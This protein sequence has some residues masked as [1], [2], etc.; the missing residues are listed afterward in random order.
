MKGNKGK[1][2]VQMDSADKWWSQSASAH[3]ML[4]PARII[5]FPAPSRS[6]LKL[7]DTPLPIPSIS[8]LCWDNCLV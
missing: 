2:L 3:V 5:F 8:H 6:A 7:T 4:C 1:I